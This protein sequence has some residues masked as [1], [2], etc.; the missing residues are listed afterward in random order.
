[1]DD[2]ELNRINTAIRAEIVKE[3]S[4]YIVQAELEGKIWLR[5]TIINPV[6]SESDL[7]S[8][9]ERVTLIGLREG[10]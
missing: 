7:K 9:L 6:T 3:G 2:N 4:F 8:L 10:V 1:M 5:L